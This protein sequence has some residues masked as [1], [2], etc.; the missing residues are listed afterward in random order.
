MLKNGNSVYFT[1]MHPIDRLQVEYR[2]QITYH[3]FGWLFF[4]QK[5]SLT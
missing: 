4:V 1:N 2:G 3:S 5:W